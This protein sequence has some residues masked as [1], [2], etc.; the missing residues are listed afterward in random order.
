MLRGLQIFEITLGSM[1]GALALMGAA[2][3]QDVKRTELGRSPVSGVEGK[4][5]IVQL[6]EIPPGATSRRHFHNGEEVFYVLEGGMAQMPGKDMKERPAGEH[7][8]NQREV[9]HAGYTVTGDKPVKILSVYIVDKGKAL[10]V[11]VP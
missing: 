8:I 1:A 9:P 3:A 10:Q 2:T 6:V 7:G 5:I 4:E 11:P